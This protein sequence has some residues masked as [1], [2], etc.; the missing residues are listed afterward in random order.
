[1]IKYKHNYYRN[2]NKM[3]NSQ[4]LSSY[5]AKTVNL[6]QAQAIEVVQ[7]TL[8]TQSGLLNNS[9][10]GLTSSAPLDELQVLLGIWGEKASDHNNLDMSIMVETSKVDANISS[11][12]GVIASASEIIRSISVDWDFYGCSQTL[13]NALNTDKIEIP[14]TIEQET[15]RSVG[16]ITLVS[17]QTLNTTLSGNKND[18]SEA[19]AVLKEKGSAPEKLATSDIRI[20]AF[21]IDPQKIKLNLEYCILILNEFEIPFKE[22]SIQMGILRAMFGSRGKNRKRITFEDIHLLLQEQGNQEHKWI[23][24]EKKYDKNDPETA[25]KKAKFIKQCKNTAS[26]INTKI[27]KTVGL[28]G[29]FL[30]TKDNECRI[31]P[32][33]LNLEKS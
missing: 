33:F 31:N 30:E 29:D 21:C 1:M 26:N 23:W 12:D 15:R 11:A 4:L 5:V 17:Y 22:N 24:R 27:S 14:I 2:K 16:G 25:K 3:E 32:K 7:K 18:L 8:S 28:A 20:I 13:S 10:I 9:L 6:N 19:V